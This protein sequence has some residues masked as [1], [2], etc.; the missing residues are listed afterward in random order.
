VGLSS[1]GGGGGSSGS[2]PFPPPQGCARTQS[3][4]DDAGPGLR[5][6][7]SPFCRCQRTHRLRDPGRRKSWILA[8]RNEACLWSSEIPA[9]DANAA[10]FSNVSDVHGLLGS[11]FQALKTPTLTL[12]GEHKDPFRYT[13]PT[14]AWNELAQS[15][16]VPGDGIEWYFDSPV[17]LRGL[18]V[19]YVA[20]LPGHRRCLAARRPAV[21]GRCRVGGHRHGD[22]VDTLNAALFPAVDGQTHRFL[23]NRNGLGCPSV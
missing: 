11:Y 10:S 18:R 1:C 23:F 16:A 21:G 4:D 12:S 8:Y 13:Y 6:G 5:S 15:G 20:G 22:G 2:S 19:A 3:V 14:R 17:P 7:Q 9:V